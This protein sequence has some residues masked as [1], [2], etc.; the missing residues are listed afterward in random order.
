[1]FL[2][3][4]EYSLKFVLAVHIGDADYTGIWSLHW[5]NR[6]RLT[7]EVDF[8]PTKV[9]ELDTETNCLLENIKQQYYIKIVKLMQ[10]KLN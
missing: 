2:K 3:Y 8:T 7:F 5:K 4:N 6:I 10:V 1:M 9:Q